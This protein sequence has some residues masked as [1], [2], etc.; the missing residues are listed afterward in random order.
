MSY[1]QNK[2]QQRNFQRAEIELLEIQDIKER[3]NENNHKKSES[4]QEAWHLK[5]ISRG[6]R[7]KQRIQEINLQNQLKEMSQ[8]Y[9]EWLPKAKAH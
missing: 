4:I 1:L 3:T 9:R 5:D 2:K 8:S 6:K 7:A